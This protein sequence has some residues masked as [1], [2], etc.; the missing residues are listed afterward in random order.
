MLGIAF[1]TRPEFIK[2]KPVMDALHGQKPFRV[3]FTGQHKDLVN[4]IP[5]EL[6]LVEITINDGRNRLDSIVSSVMNLECLDGLT[7]LMVQG[8]TSSAFAMALAAFHRKIK[9]IHLEAG[10]RTYDFNNPYPEEA[11]RQLISRI[12]DI[13]LC[14]TKL[15]HD[16]LQNEMTPGQ[17]HVV[18]NTVLDNLVDV[19]VTY[20]NEVLITMHRRENHAII[21]Q[22][23]EKLETISL[24]YPSLQFT[25][26]SHP[27]PNV[28]KH[29]S[30]L[31]NVQVI[32]PMGHNDFINRLA[33]CKF[34]ITDSGG[35][36]EES[37]FLR[38]YSIV[39]R[40]ETERKSGVGRWAKLC[41]SPENLES[42]VSEM[43]SKG[44]PPSNW[45][46]PYGDGTSAQ[47]IYNILQDML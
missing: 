27:N 19:P 37:S 29:L 15:S 3:I 21:P 5:N 22:W 42:L 24:Q 16:N 13:H 4:N 25:F 7:H 45:V 41:K 28:K 12:T 23:F 31:N 26:V 11:N 18:G 34:I 1:G 36:Q 47:K 39:C 6:D 35:L 38:K 43:D 32:E 14:P 40:R 46:C 30:K 17:K 9:I 8:D 10:L 33:A 20:S 2:L 44:V